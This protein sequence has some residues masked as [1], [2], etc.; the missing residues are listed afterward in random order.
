MRMLESVTDIRLL[1]KKNRIASCTNC[2]FSP[3]STLAICHRNSLSPFVSMETKFGRRGMY[4]I[5]T[6]F[7]EDYKGLGILEATFGSAFA[8]NGLT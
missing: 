1:D 7:I 3:P 2:F 5:P 6:L 8:G 4:L